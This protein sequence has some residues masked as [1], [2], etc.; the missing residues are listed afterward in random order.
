[1]PKNSFDC[2]WDLRRGLREPQMVEQLVHV[3]YVEQIADDPVPGHS[4]HGRSG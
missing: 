1:M 2:L 3:A 4:N